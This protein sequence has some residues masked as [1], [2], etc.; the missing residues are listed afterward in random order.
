[1]RGTPKHNLND[2][3]YERKEIKITNKRNLSWSNYFRE[4]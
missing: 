3:S 2:V 1:M 4:S